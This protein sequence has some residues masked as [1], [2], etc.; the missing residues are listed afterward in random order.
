ML[1]C[2][3]QKNNNMNRLSLNGNSTFYLLQLKIMEAHQ[4]QFCIH[5]NNSLYSEIMYENGN[6]S[7]M[8]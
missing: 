1:D 6:D 8:F 7:T 5:L 2:Y 4:A 3:I